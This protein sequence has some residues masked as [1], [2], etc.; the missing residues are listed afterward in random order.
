MLGEYKE[1]HC[2][3]IQLYNTAQSAGV[4][5]DICMLFMM[6]LLDLLRMHAAPGWT[7]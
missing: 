7:L 2:R 1:T 3:Y 5:R 4:G 6:S